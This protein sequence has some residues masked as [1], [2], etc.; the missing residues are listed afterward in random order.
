[1][2][3]CVL[4]TLE[5]VPNQLG[6]VPQGMGAACS[7]ANIAIS[8]DSDDGASG[9]STPLFGTKVYNVLHGS[10]NVFKKKGYV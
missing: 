1:M 6:E 8:D 10:L 9:K 7:G 2:L 5:S 3:Q 4:P